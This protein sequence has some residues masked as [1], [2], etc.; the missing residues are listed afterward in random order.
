MVSGGGEIGEHLLAWGA[1]RI[2]RKSRRRHLAGGDGRFRFVDRGAEDETLVFHEGGDKRSRDVECRREHDADCE[3]V[4]HEN[5][6]K[7]PQM[8]ILHLPLRTFILLTSALSTIVPRKAD[9]ACSRALLG[10]GSLFTNTF[11]ALS[12]P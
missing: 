11:K 9:S 3:D 4:S 12:F 8:R 5:A 6:E 10:F 7:L 1:Y 2:R